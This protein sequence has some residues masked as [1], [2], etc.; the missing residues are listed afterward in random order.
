M[1]DKHLT[2]YDF[3]DTDLLHKLAQEVDPDTGMISSED[4]AAALGMEDDVRAV[5]MRCAWMR[6]YGFFARDD[7]LG[8]WRLTRGGERIVEAH[9][10]ASTEKAL[11]AVPEEAMVDVMAHV[12]KRYRHGDP[13]MATLL[14]R[15]FL[16]GTTP[17]SA[18]F[19]T[20]G[21]RR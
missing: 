13:L 6:R 8:V 3:R 7:R 2:L 21:G 16:F 19:A 4:L 15:E 1:A 12:T 14:R 10:R 9:L 20:R 11:E 5:A 18:A 17:R